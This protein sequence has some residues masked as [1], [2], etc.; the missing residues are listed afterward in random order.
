MAVPK[1]TAARKQLRQ[2]LAAIAHHGD[3]SQ[4]ELDAVASTMR[5][6]TRRRA[7]KPP[8]KTA[9]AKP[10]PKA[11]STPPVKRGPGRPRKD[12]NGEKEQLLELLKEGTTFR[13]ACDEV[14]VSLATMWNWY[15]ADEIFRAAF[16]RAREAAYRSRIDSALDRAQAAE[17][18]DQAYCARVVAD[19][20]LKT[21]ELHQRSQQLQVNVT[22]GA[23]GPVTITWAPGGLAV[24]GETQAPQL[25]IEGKA[26]AGG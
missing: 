5:S 6:G 3:I 10:A 12:Q 16:A 24:G 1:G 21:L 13:R 20:A 4:A 25:V 7:A 8:A 18:K 17:D 2:K 11:A 9:A 14:G 15:E 19:I 26:E 23:S 22:G